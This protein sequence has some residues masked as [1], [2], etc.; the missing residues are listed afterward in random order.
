MNMPLPPP[1]GD[2]S[3]YRPPVIVRSAE[4]VHTQKLLREESGVGEMRLSTA[5]EVHRSL[6]AVLEK[7]RAAI[8]RIP[9]G[10]S[11][12]DAFPTIMR[13]RQELQKRMEEVAGAHWSAR[14]PYVAI[15]LQSPWLPRH[16]V[17][18]ITNMYGQEE[19]TLT[20]KEQR[21]QARQ[22]QETDKPE[23]EVKKKSWY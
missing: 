15:A 8:A 7:H 20:R 1:D 12:Q 23:K 17:D 3:Y 14:A 5:W 2:T 16:L 22:Q 11:M 6:A 13:V 4:I 18:R 10:V 19:P 21:E 9:N